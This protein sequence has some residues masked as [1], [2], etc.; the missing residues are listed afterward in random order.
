[1]WWHRG[2]EYMQLPSHQRRASRFIDRDFQVR[3]AGVV[4]VAAALGAIFAFVPIIMFLNQNYRIFI[5]LAH[6]FAPALMDDLEREQI[7]VTGLLFVGFSGLT[8]F[9]MILSFKLTNRIVGPLKVIRNHLRR[10]SRGQWHIAPVRIRDTDEFQDMVD[11]YNYFYESFRTNLKR[12][13]EMIKKLK[14]DP[15]DKESFNAWR[16][17]IEEKSMQLNLKADLPYPVLSAL[18]GAT[19]AESRDSRRVS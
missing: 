10:L 8:T 11:S 18:S 1:M 3:Y 6:Q 16:T 5:D 19:N 2:F 9:F 14:I 15:E 4:I 13:L 17:L 12:D 7:W